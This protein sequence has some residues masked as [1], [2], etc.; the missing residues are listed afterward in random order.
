MVDSG[1]F[2][3]NQFNR[4]QSD[5]ALRLHQSNYFNL[6]RFHLSVQFRKMKREYETDGK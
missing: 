3:F 1:S 6:Q 4:K 5:L 2:P